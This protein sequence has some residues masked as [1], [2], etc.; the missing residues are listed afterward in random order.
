VRIAIVGDQAGFRKTLRTILEKE[1]GLTV[2]AE[3][4]NGLDA[5]GAVIEHKPEVVLMGAS[6]P[7]MNGLDAAKVIRSRFPKTRIV[8]LS[9]HSDSS[10]TAMSCQA[11]ACYHLCKDCNPEEIIAAIRD[12]H[13]SR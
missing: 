8:I 9:M 11:G 7:V 2:V 12:G 5:I 6:M 10:Q 4:R 1:P 13:Q 3:A